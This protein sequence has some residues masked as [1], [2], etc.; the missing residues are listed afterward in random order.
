[1][2]NARTPGVVSLDLSKITNIQQLA[3]LLAPYFLSSS[4]GTAPGAQG[5]SGGRTTVLTTASKYVQSLNGATGLVTI[6]P[7]QVKQAALIAGSYP[8]T[9]AT[10]FA[11]A[12]VVF[13]FP[14]G[15]PT[16]GTTL[17]ASAPSATAVTITSTNGSDVRVL[18]LLAIG[19]PS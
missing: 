17:Y 12:P 15:A 19:N 11:S 6:P 16:A 13:A 9:F 14:I 1:M 10:P 18:E 7:V 3:T 2:H 4:L 8:W 5:G